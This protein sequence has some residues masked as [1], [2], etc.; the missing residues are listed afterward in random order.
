MF[1]S[2]FSSMLG[3][4]LEREFDRSTSETLGIA[5]YI[6]GLIK[7]IL[8]RARELSAGPNALPDFI[9]SAL[10]RKIF[11]TFTDDRY[12]VLH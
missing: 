8:L 5:L 9:P 1:H 2:R 4:F 6:E 10:R 7:L 3:S 11:D 12:S